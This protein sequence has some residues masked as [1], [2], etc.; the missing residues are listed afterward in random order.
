MEILSTLLEG[1]NFWINLVF[2]AL[3][4]I[5]ILATTI[6]YFRTQEKRALKYKIKTINL[7]SR[8]IRGISDLKILFKEQE[9]TKFSTSLVSVWNQG[10]KIINKEDLASSE[11]VEIKSK[12]KDFQIYMYE[13]VSIENRSNNFKLTKEKESI[14]L[15]FEYLGLNEGIT[16][17]LYHNSDSA[18]RSIIVSG[19]LKKEGAISEG[20]YD[21]IKAIDRIYEPIFNPIT[22]LT[23]AIFGSNKFQESINISLVAIIFIASIPLLIPIMIV[24]KYLSS[25]NEIPR[26]FKAFH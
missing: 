12:T 24:V 25:K 19:R 17:R 21:D 2:L 22:K 8:K 20:G 18:M 23:I 11:P 14:K 15:N 3:A 1:N 4:I 16:L 6:T 7:L 26:P 10:K 9:I 13:I 5:G